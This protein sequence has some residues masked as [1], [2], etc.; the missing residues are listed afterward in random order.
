MR[1]RILI[2]VD[3]SKTIA[4]TIERN[5]LH[6]RRDG[7]AM[8]VCVPNTP[9][10]PKRKTKVQFVQDPTIELEAIAKASVGI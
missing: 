1:F 6:L 7:S 4:E 5:G 10:I 9:A 8:Q 3:V 2:D